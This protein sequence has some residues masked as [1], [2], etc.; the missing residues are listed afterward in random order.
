MKIMRVV[1]VLLAFLTLSCSAK[2]RQ[3]Q[4]TSPGAE[5]EL[6]A[7]LFAAIKANNWG[8]FE[9]L[10]ITSADFT[11]KR[12]NLSPVQAKQSYAGASLRPNLI[13]KLRT[14][15]NRAVAGGAGQ[16]DFR[17]AFFVGLGPVT[18]SGNLSD[19]QNES[20]PFTTYSLK[21]DTGGRVIDATDLTP[22]FVV[23]PW[24]KGLRLLK[25]EF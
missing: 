15:F 6:G 22:R 25:L 21:I 8:A 9:P 2:S 18:A 16:I 5:F 10:T 11:L 17:Q 20:I 4:P 1:A 14:D 13:A 12:M 24:E 19:I 23:V 7:K 3:Q